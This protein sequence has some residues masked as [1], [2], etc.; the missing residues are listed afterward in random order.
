MAD[1]VIPLYISHQPARVQT[2][3]AS[4]LREPIARTCR[5]PQPFGDVEQR[6]SRV[7]SLAA[8]VSR[9]G[10]KQMRIVIADAP[11]LTVTGCGQSMNCEHFLL[12]SRLPRLVLRS[13]ESPGHDN[14]RGQLADRHGGMRPGPGVGR[15]SPAC[16]SRFAVIAACGD[17][18]PHRPCRIRITPVLCRSPRRRL[19]SVQGR[20]PEP[21]SRATVRYSTPIDYLERRHARAQTRRQPAAP[22]FATHRSRPYVPMSPPSLCLTRSARI[23]HRLMFIEQC[24]GMVRRWPL[25]RAQRDRDPP[26]SVLNQRVASL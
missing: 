17:G 26:R 15:G 7:H 13:R 19:R 16:G 5:Q 12:Q 25:R 23:Y 11:R 22:A 3:T 21:I 10:G 14:C 20:S 1:C 2:G 6:L 4:A 9:R 18:H 8:E 24:L